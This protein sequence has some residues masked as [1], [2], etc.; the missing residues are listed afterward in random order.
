VEQ[1]GCE[2]ELKKTLTQLPTWILPQGGHTFA[3]LL[4]LSPQRGVFFALFGDVKKLWFV[5]EIIY[6]HPPSIWLRLLHTPNF[7][8]RPPNF[9]I[10]AKLVNFVC[11]IGLV[12]TFSYPAN[13]QIFETDVF[14]GVLRRFCGLAEIGRPCP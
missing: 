5:G 1:I 11:T 14:G 7:T 9:F 10:C 13:F 6:P 8:P 3:L 4:S 12:M 2:E